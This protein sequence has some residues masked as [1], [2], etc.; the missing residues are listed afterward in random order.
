MLWLGTARLARFGSSANYQLTHS[1]FFPKRC[2]LP[3]V[4]TRSYRP[5]DDPQPDNPTSFV[6][7]QQQLREADPHI[8]SADEQLG[9]GFQVGDVWACA[10]MTPASDSLARWT[11]RWVLSCV[12]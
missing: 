7:T 5:F 4:E 3:Q 12:L 1:Y 11:L 10:A 2:F 6:L 8:L 9:A